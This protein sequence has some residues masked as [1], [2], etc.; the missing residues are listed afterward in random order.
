[1]EP[2]L[3]Y[4]DL[5]AFVEATTRGYREAMRAPTAAADALLTGAPDLD[6]DLVDASAEYLSTR[7]ADD[8]EA[9]GRQ[10]PEVWERFA[11][12]LD[13]AGMLSEPVD[14]DDAFTDEYLPG[15]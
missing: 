5:R 6:P 15:S 13:E 12:F 7:Y 11:D 14:V 4:E 2:A 10:D 9:W 1:M 3:P 8:P